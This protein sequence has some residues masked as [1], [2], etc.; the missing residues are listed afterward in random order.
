MLIG[1]VVGSTTLASPAFAHDGKPPAPHDLWSSWSLEPVAILLLGLSLG[2][3]VRGTR[4]VWR[5]AGRGR[6]TRSIDV[7]AFAAGWMVLALAILSP[8]HAVGS[9]LLSAHMVQHELLIA[10]ATPL[11]VLGR[12]VVPAL[13]A[14]SPRVRARAGRMAHMAAIRG[15]WRWMSR[16]LNAAVIHGA[17]IWVWHAPRPYEAAVRSP[18]LHAAEHA[19]FIL[20]AL[21]FWWAVLHTRSSRARDGQAITAMFLTA[22]HTGA[23]GAL[24]TFAGDLW[25][26][27]YAATTRPWGLSPLEDQQLA[28]LIMWIP[29]GGVYVLAGLLLA[30]RWMGESR[31]LP[32][33]RTIASLL[34]L[35]FIVACQGGLDDDRTPSVLGGNA[36]RGKVAMTQY[37][38]T[39]CHMIP[40]I[41]GARGTVGPSLAGIGARGFIAGVLPN[42]PDNMVRWIMNPRQVDSLTAMPDLGVTDSL[43]RDM[44][45]YLYRIH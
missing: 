37:G 23:L 2:L 36:Q 38:C 34:L 44:A 40:G 10:I 6:G 18:A 14:V 21:L 27:T 3:Y 29:G 42:S 32:H 4:R 22:L 26:P 1:A 24:L 28:G 30:A 39:S 25:Y 7:M 5:A 19:T 45:E 41:A 13:W 17:S 9:A 43:A 33:A 11:L 15:T 12:P 35:V 20:T 8:I 16:P 31:W